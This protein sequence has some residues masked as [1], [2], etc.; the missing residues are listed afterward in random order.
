MLSPIVFDGIAPT[1]YFRNANI[2]ISFELLTLLIE[3]GLFYAVF[4]GIMPK[5]RLIQAICLIMIGNAITFFISG[6]IY[7]MFF[8]YEWLF[9]GWGT[10]PIG[11]FLMFLSIIGLIPSFSIVISLYLLTKSLE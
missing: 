4:K 3:T 2:V 9:V 1:F 6:C 10:T 5:K 11:E 7:T 8:G